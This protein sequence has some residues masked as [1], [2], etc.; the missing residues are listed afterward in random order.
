MNC[1]KTISVKK[2]ALLPVVGAEI[3]SES[4]GDAID[5]STA[6]SATFILV[7]IMT[8]EIVL[9]EDATV[10]DATNGKL[11]YQWQSTETDTT[12]TYRGYFILIFDSRPEYFP[13]SND[14]ALIIEIEEL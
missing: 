11:F 12:G 13:A 6:S 1:Q 14:E 2:G 8:G 10:S 9:N 5:I 7:N 3:T 4:T